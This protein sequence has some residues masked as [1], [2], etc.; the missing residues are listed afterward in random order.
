MFD[1]VYVFRCFVVHLNNIIFILLWDD[2]YNL[3]FVQWK[4]YMKAA[5]KV[6]KKRR[7]E[8]L[9]KIHSITFY[10][11]VTKSN[12]I[13]EIRSTHLSSNPIWPIFLKKKNQTNSTQFDLTYATWILHIPLRKRNWYLLDTDSHP[14]RFRCISDTPCGILDYFIYFDL[15][16]RSSILFDTLKYSTS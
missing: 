14:I 9:K 11:E 1:I 4:L 16:I 3:H 12:L 10:F 13:W 15:Q 5:A 7:G 6:S 8:I 2:G